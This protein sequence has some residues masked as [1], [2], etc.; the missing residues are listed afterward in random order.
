M[1]VSL[2]KPIL[3]VEGID[4]LHTIAHLLVRH[5]LPPNQVD[6]REAKGDRNVLD[7]MRNAVVATADTSCSIGFVIDADGPVSQR[8]ESVRYHLCD[9][10]LPLDTILPDTGYIGDS[11]TLA[12]RV[13]VWIMPDNEVPGTLEDFLHALVPPGD[14]LIHHAHEATEKAVRL[15]AEFPSQDRLKAKLYCW[16]AWQKEP[17]RPFGVALNCKFFRHD[18]V[19]ALKF[20]EWFK[21]LYRLES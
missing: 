10:G 16:L 19:V 6:I 7:I 13:G 12:L 11:T 8:W 1:A 2:T 4:D 9:L 3:H 20:V 15:G 5:G 21:N 18:S 17:G 14:S